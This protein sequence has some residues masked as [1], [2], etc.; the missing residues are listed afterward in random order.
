MVVVYVSGFS[1]HKGLFKYDIRIFYE[2]FLS[3]F[4]PLV[5]LWELHN[6]YQVIL[7]RGKLCILSLIC[8]F[9]WYPH[10]P[11]E[12]YANCSL[13]APRCSF[14]KNTFDC[15]YKRFHLMWSLNQS[16]IQLM[17]LNRQNAGKCLWM[18]WEENQLTI[19]S[20]TQ[21]FNVGFECGTPHNFVVSQVR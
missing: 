14:K 11:T 4:F 17:L 20:C 7:L 6:Y 8:W 12:S 9:R 13:G 10:L 1:T 15:L 16:D 2:I 5:T 18:L 3:L 21:R 19:M